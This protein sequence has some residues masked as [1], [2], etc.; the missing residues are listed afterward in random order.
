MTVEAGKLNINFNVV[1]N[2]CTNRQSEKVEEY[3]EAPMPLT[4]ENDGTFF[5]TCTNC[6]H[7]VEITP[8]FEYDY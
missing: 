5:F 1:C 3:V 7:V 2:K 4:E 8:F 6:K